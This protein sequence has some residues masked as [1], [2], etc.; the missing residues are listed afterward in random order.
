MNKLCTLKTEKAAV[1][2]ENLDLA[3]NFRRIEYTFRGQ[4][5]LKSCLQ[6]RLLSLLKCHNCPTTIWRDLEQTFT[7]SSKLNFILT[8]SE[9]AL[10]KFCT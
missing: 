9:L 4:V 6:K 10:G 8:S 5:F 2:Q 7:R 3:S 1:Y